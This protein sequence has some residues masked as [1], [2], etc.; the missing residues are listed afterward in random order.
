M[1]VTGASRTVAALALT[2]ASAVGAANC[3]AGSSD[4]T[5]KASGFNA[6]VTGVVNPSDRRG[7]TLRL[8]AFGDVDNW[9]PARGY[10]SPAWNL[11]RL[12]ARTLVTLAAQPGNAGTRLVPDLAKALPEISGDGLTY[13]FSLKSGLKFEDGAPITS[14]DI[15][16]GLERVFAQDVVNGGPTY[17]IEY[18]DQGQGYPGPYKDTDPDKLGLR[19]VQTPDDTTIVFRLRAPYA[20]FLHFL[21]MGGAAPVPKA[22]DTGARYADRPVSSGPYKFKVM[23][24]GKHVV[25]VRNP[26]WNRSTDSVRKALP[27][28]VDLSIGVDPNE[29]DRRLIDGI[30]DADIWPNGVQPASQAKILLSPKLKANLDAAYN[31]L[32]RYAAINAAVPPFD[33][34]HC[35]RAVHYAADKTA[36]QTAQG[37]PEAGGDIA[38]NMLPP[39]I[40]G[41]DAGTDPYHTASGK[42]QL[43]LVHEE[44]VR[45]GQP[46]GFRTVLAVP[47][48][49]KV[50][51]TA[52]ALQQALAAAGIDARI[53]PSDPG[54]YLQEVGTPDN[55]HRKGLGLMLAGW[56]ADFPSGSGFLPPL[57][58]GRTIEPSGNNNYAE[59]NDPEINSLI[60]RGKAATSPG[61][62]A[63]MW[64][65]VNA[66]VMDSA[67]LL[68]ILYEKSL[69]YR[70]PRLTNVFVNPSYGHW[71]FAV[72]G[73][74]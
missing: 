67:A 51:R 62:A 60:D 70:N 29:I 32:L 64:K 43:Q 22:F 35:R 23:E 55:V 15:K 24:P 58:D 72:L 16:Y 42:P 26:N 46:A 9:D 4:S 49:P 61:A 59:M 19:S 1:N 2:L 8:A 74:A 12:Y 17:L 54:S 27:D 57:V 39:F 38:V 20:D 73:V 3:T 53:E 41:Y 45:C 10:T 63:E 52:E 44:L 11:Q 13:R 48:I 6:G 33:N 50:V 69:S 5:R 66:K 71:D 34:I 30:V 37:G 47:G 28:E 68:P 21:A 7:G 36:M 40:A 31:G 18:L 14:R 25:M 65:Q 56:G